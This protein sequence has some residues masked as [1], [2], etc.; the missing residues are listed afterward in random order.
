MQVLNSTGL[1]DPTSCPSREFGAGC[2][3]SCIRG[4][5]P[6]NVTFQCDVTSSNTGVWFGDITCTPFNCG[7]IS[8]FQFD[9]R[10]TVVGSRNCTGTALSFNPVTRQ[11]T[12]NTLFSAT[13]PPHRALRCQSLGGFF[14]EDRVVECAPDGWILAASSQASHSGRTIA[15]FCRRNC[16]AFVP[17]NGQHFAS[18]LGDTGAGA[19]CSPQCTTNANVSASFTCSAAGLWVESTSTASL[20]VRPPTD[21]PTQPVFASSGSE[22]SNVGADVVVVVI[23]IVAIIILVLVLLYYFGYLR[24]LGLAWDAKRPGSK[25]TVKKRT[26]FNEAYI[27]PKQSAQDRD[28]IYGS[29]VSNFPQATTSNAPSAAAMEI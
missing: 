24:C 17:I 11:C 27:V 18:C 21:A 25:G 5:V 3:V 20:C 15:S 10:A 2:Q 6:K 12:A 9:S 29:V 28:A 14:T 8:N 13:S 23:P 4:F 19:T 26:T 1:V 7:P 16:G 22:S